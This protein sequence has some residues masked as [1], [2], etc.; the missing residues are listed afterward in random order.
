MQVPSLSSGCEIAQF[1]VRYM[2]V[3]C[4]DGLEKVPTQSYRTLY[5][6]TGGPIHGHR[7]TPS[8]MFPSGGGGAC[9]CLC[10][11]GCVW[12]RYGEQKIAQFRTHYLTK[13]SE[14]VSTQSSGQ[15]NTFLLNHFS[16]YWKVS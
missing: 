13:E 4:K 8:A 10:V 2:V 3:F 5:R 6:C 12:V 1:F 14:Y 9:S 16:V 11:F 15:L 7:L